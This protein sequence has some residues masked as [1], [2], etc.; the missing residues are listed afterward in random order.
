MGAYERPG[1]EPLALALQDRHGLNVNMLLWCLWCGAYFREPGELVIRKAIDQTHRWN[2]EV[3]KPLRAA[4]TALKFDF[5]GAD[6]ERQG[7]L[8]LKIKDDELAAE[9]IELDTLE[10]LALD[11]LAAASPP[12]GTERA[13][14][15]VALYARLAGAAR[16]PGFTVSLLEEL[17]ANTLDLVESKTP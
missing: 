13:R 10:R 16:T 2:H 11:A 7:A 8:R 9:R 6:I 15:A 14:R 4:R 12:G 5:P 17:I 3:T 1:V